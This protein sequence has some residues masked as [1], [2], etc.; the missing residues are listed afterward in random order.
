MVFPSPSQRVLV[1]VLVL[2]ASSIA[3]IASAQTAAPPPPPP[4]PVAPAP[5]TTTTTTI[6]TTTPPAPAPA[7]PAP[8]PPA[9]PEAAPA[10]AAAPPA[11]A[12][13]PTPSVL[14]KVSADAFVDAYASANWLNSPKPQG[15]VNTAGSGPPGGNTFRA[16]DSNQGFSLNWIGLNANYAADPIGGTIGLRMGPGTTPYNAGPDNVNGM[17]FVKQ[18]YVT[19][20][21]I[22]KLTLDLGKWDEPFGSEVADSQ[23]NMNYTRSYLFWYAQP[24]FFTGLRI[25][26]AFAAAFDAKVFAANGWNNTVDN[27]RGKTFGVQLTVVPS[28]LATIYLGYVGGPEQNDY[29]TGAATAT[30]V[31][32]VANADSHMRQLADLVADINPTKQLRFLLN[33][34]FGAE[35]DLPNTGAPG[36][37][38]ELWYGVNL[39]IRYAFTDAF[40]GTLRGEVF[41]DKFG[42]RLGAATTL[43]SGVLTLGYGVGSHLAFM[44]D[45]RID[46]SSDSVFQQGS[47]GSAKT[48]FTTTLGVIASTK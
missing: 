18:A 19:W 26:Y 33:G 24:L 45:N 9:P 28:D 32:D 36:T 1:P 13:A 7:A 3:S 5:P 39:A 16:F 31:T 42:D 44:L 43:E 30:G 6:T 40:Y 11:A 34:D 37:H 21:P 25:D 15:P 10:P 23:L 4:A 38:N 41:K 46:G 22:D 8:P 2:C 35:D 17:Q 14:D 20:K 27:N 29:A 48:Q 47:A 12:A